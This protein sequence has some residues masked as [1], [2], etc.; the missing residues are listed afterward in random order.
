[1]DV[2]VVVVV[3]HGH[4][5]DHEDLPTFWQTAFDTADP[6]GLGRSAQKKSCETK[7]RPVRYQGAHIDSS[8]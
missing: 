1:V 5:H 4:D 7:L 6:S 8:R 2:D 3:I